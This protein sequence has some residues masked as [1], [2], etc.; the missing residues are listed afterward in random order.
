MNRL[1]DYGHPPALEDLEFDLRSLFY[2]C[3]W[4]SLFEPIVDYW[5]LDIVD[6]TEAE[7]L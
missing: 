2:S 1:R 4:C 5:A 3:S 6:L 7:L